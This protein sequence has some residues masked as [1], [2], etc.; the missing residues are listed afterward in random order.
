MRRGVLAW[1]LTFALGYAGTMARAADA[2]ELKHP[3]NK[4]A[5]E[6]YRV[7]T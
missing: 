5:P 7:A 1:L 2:P 6:G 4:S 3:L